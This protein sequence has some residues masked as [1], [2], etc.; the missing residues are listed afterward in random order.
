MPDPTNPL[1]PPPTP[2]I[3]PAQLMQVFGP[4][5]AAMGMGAG[6][7][8]SSQLA[9]QVQQAQQGADQAFQQYQSAAQAPEPQGNN[10]YDQL[11]G[12]TASV[13]SG[14]QDYGRQANERGKASDQAL[15]QHRLDNLHA[16]KDNYDRQAQA[17]EK[18]G[19]T[20]LAADMREKLARVTGQIPIVK[21]AMGDAAHGA[22]VDTGQA[23]AGLRT[24]ATTKSNEKIAAGHDAAS[25]ERARIA[26]GA[27]GAGGVRDTANDP[28]FDNMTTRTDFGSFIDKSKIPIKLQPAMLAYAAEKGATV[29]DAK[30]RGALEDMESS[31]RTLQAQ[32]DQI[33]DKL[34]EGPQDRPM[35]AAK[36]MALKVSGADPI[37]AGF[38]SMWANTVR[39]MRAQAGS[40]GLRINKSEIERAIKWDRPDPVW[41]TKPI[42]DQKMQNWALIRANAMSP[43][44]SNDWRSVKPSGVVRVMDPNGTVSTVKAI[45]AEGL[46]KNKG[47]SRVLTQDDFPIAGQKTSANQAAGSKD[48]NYKIVNGQMVPE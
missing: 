7:Q 1:A 35:V 43:L 41:D 29:V 30:Q 47:Y 19:N 25:I 48:I 37:L 31:W 3:D 16:L 22:A 9:P 17:A 32:T 24:G 40:G 2:P 10:F 6:D 20:K 33:R 12:N 26:A 15:A 23:G 45:Q 11:L 42:L 36:N 38:D 34:A 27:K 18:L 39:T 14:N 28:T 21:Q 46:I 4:I 13:L 8:T 44:M 5:L